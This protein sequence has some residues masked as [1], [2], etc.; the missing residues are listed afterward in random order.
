MN[1]LASDIQA[2][3]LTFKLAGLTTLILLVLGVPLAWWLSRH[4]NV[5]KVL[6]STLVTLPLILPPTV[7]GF[8]LLVLFSPNQLLGH[9]IQTH[10][11]IQLVFSFSGLL[12]AS[13]I[14]SLPFMV[15]PLQN[16]FE[17]W[18]HSL[19][20]SAMMMGASFY[21]RF[22]FLILPSNKTALFSAVLLTF[23]HTLGEFGIVLMIGG[24]IPGETQL[25]SIALFEHVES[26]NYTQAHQLALIL[27]CFATLLIFS[28]KYFTRDQLW[29][30]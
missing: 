1:L 6:C 8:Y 22:F 10:L 17:Q 2:L 14:Y 24:N 11:D 4:Q 5:F 3:M 25:A 23:A 9:W 28:L 30:V 7:I 19:D 12:I 27:L 18:H 13:V 21:Q 26:L 15:Q 16:A 20:E 29:K